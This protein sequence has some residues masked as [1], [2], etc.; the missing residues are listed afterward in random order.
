MPRQEALFQMAGPVETWL[1]ER[2]PETGYRDFY[3]DLFPAGELEAKGEQEHGRYTGIAVQVCADRARRYTVTDDL[4][5]IDELVKSDDFCIMSPVSYAGKAQRQEMARFLYA[6]VIDLDGIRVEGDEAVGLHELIYQMTRIRSTRA[7][8]A[9]LPLPTYIV[10]SGRGVHLY[11]LL[12]RPIPLFRNVIRQLSNLRRSLISDIWNSYV[13]EL[14]KN[15]QF[16]SVTQSFRMVG[17]VTKDGGRVR[18]YRV[19]DRVSMEYLNS[20]VHDPEARVTQFAYKTNLSL[21]EA[22]K[23][24]PQWYQKRIVEGQQRG[25]WTVKRDLYD[26]WKRRLER[27]AREGHRYFCV[28]A[29]AIYGRKCAIPR[30]EVERDALGL[31]AFLDGLGDKQVNPFTVSDVM[32]ALEAYN[33][34]Y[35][36]FP[37]RSIET[38]TGVS[39]PPNKRNGRNLRTHLALARLIQNF[40][41]PEGSWRNT[42]GAPT[43]G[44]LVCEYAAAHPGASQREIAA[45]LGISKTTV[46]KWLKTK[47]AD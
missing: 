32:K 5:V 18:A 13:T 30:E 6:L 23:K 38:L 29:L 1:S 14:S 41:D 43:K 17:S 22:R 3:R 19:G 12:T 27:E 2:Y 20:H 15:K 25:T 4:E 28:M 16:E 11:Y 26:W 40:N 24:Y 47:K 31:V 34:C 7:A 46:N 45:A 10:S 33:A 42:K 35:Q 39:I 37:R 9:A 44:T 36:T 21:E 8:S